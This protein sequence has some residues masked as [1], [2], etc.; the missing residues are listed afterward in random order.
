MDYSIT[1]S[2]P[3]LGLSKVIKTLSFP[4]ASI[5]VSDLVGVIF[6]LMST[7]DVA[8]SEILSILDVINTYG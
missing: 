2:I 8:D 6:T 4:A 3:E 7:I 1:L 5:P